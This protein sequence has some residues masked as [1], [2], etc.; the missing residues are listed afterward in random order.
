M[1]R[2]AK[3]ENVKRQ[4]QGRVTLLAFAFWL[5]R[6]LATQ[7]PLNR[8]TAD[9]GSPWPPCCSQIAGCGLAGLGRAPVSRPEWVVGVGVAGG[10]AWTRRWMTGA[11]ASATCN[12]RVVRAWLLY[13]AFRAC[14]HSPRSPALCDVSRSKSR[15][16]RNAGSRRCADSASDVGGRRLF[17]ASSGAGVPSGPFSVA[18]AGS[19]GRF[20]LGAGSNPIVAR[21]TRVVRYNDRA[22]RRGRSEFGRSFR[23]ARA[24]AVD[25]HA[26]LHR[27]EIPGPLT[28][29][30]VNS[31]GGLRRSPMRRRNTRTTRS[32][33]V[34]LLDSTQ[35][36]K[37]VR[38]RSHISR[39][40]P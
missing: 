32:R 7:S 4:V 33:G 34:V 15:E 23:T 39:L 26:L 8:P 28:C 6:W 1:W 37:N 36:P 27:A 29:S 35:N 25:L 18:G 20:V 24:M 12:A 19:G 10:T 16:P 9:G 17:L 21:E 30:P 31:F 38:A 3:L 11:G 5:L 2:R 13:P 22:V 40:L 14:S